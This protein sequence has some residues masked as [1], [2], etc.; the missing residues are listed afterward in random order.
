MSRRFDFSNIDLQ[1]ELA[2]IEGTEFVSWLDWHE[3][4]R[5]RKANPV[6]TIKTPFSRL[7]GKYELSVGGYHLWGGYSG[8]G[9]STLAI[10]TAL[11]AA[12]ENKVAIASLEME[13]EDVVEMAYQM[14]A[15]TTRVD[16]LY[17]EKI[18]HWLE[19]RVMSYD[20]ID[21]IKPAEAIQ[22]CIHAAKN[23]CKL[24]LLD[25]LFM[26]EGICADVEAEQHFTQKLAE[27]GKRFNVA[28]LLIHHMRKPEQNEKKIPS[29]SGFIGSS[30]MVNASLS[31]A[32]VWRDFE[33]IGIRDQGLPNEESEP[34]VVL[35]V[36]KNRHFKFH[37]NVRLYEHSSR[38]LC[39]SSVR[40]VKRIVEL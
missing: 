14:I 6:P 16:E 28:I 40:R 3:A 39:E 37:G 11:H 4:Y 13:K 22:M 7:E 18:A 35:K 17:E 20:R 8:H 23:G 34:D 12:Q 2:P 1:E 25:C 31:C 33:L 15:G 32:I 10:Q 24:I 29:K 5:Y 26:I 30:H 38:L 36:D 19:P 21:T 27:V 9:K